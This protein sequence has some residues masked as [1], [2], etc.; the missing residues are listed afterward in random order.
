MFYPFLSHLCFDLII[1]N[2]KYY[3]HVAAAAA[4]FFQ[5]FWCSWNNFILQPKL[6]PTAT[7]LCWRN[8]SEIVLKLS[9]C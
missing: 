2:F 1:L 3:M 5:H 7:T 4:V 6:M 9:K 8:F